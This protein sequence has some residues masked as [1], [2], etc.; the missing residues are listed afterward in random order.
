MIAAETT[1]AAAI[2]FPFW[3]LVFEVYVLCGA[4]L[5]ALAAGQAFFLIYGKLLVCNHL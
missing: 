4:H 2:I 5:F 3:L 1:S